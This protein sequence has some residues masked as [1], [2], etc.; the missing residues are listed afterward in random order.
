MICGYCKQEKKPFIRY[1]WGKTCCEDCYKKRKMGKRSKRT[2][3]E[4]KQMTYL[5]TEID[6]KFSIYIRCLYRKPNGLITCYTCDKEMTLQEAQCGHY[7]SRKDACT[8]WL[9]DNVRCQCDY[10]NVTLGGNLEVFKERLEKEN[11]GI[12]DIINQ[13]GYQVWHHSRE[14]LDKLLQEIKVKTK[15][16]YSG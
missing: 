9:I 14:D 12:T 7:N 3:K 8:R 16:I 6:R 2:R 10:C 4:G 1:R 13:M 15:N 5:K 11:P